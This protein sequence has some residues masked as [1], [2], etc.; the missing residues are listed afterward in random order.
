MDLALD[1]SPTPVLILSLTLLS[2][3]SPSVFPLITCSPIALS[4][5]QFNHNLLQM[6]T[7]MSPVKLLA[8]ILFMHISD[9][10]VNFR[11]SW[12]D[13]CSPTIRELDQDLGSATGGCDHDRGPT[14]RGCD[15]NSSHPLKPLL[16]PCPGPEF[17]I[18]LD[19]HAHECISASTCPLMH[20]LLRHLS[21]PPSSTS[22]V[23]HCHLQS[24][25]SQQDDYHTMAH[26]PWRTTWQILILSLTRWS[27]FFK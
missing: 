5:L 11:K 15:H 3:T 8:F 4:L 18:L 22:D 25:P 23:S 6:L 10:Q 26:G 14:T 24:K 9:N 27:Q 12:W 21:S 2:H 1:L 16:V 17:L 13:T 20:E 7:C 19:V